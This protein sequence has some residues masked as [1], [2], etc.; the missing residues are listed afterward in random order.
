MYKDIKFDFLPE[1]NSLC[2]GR[3]IDLYIER[4]KEW[5]SDK[6]TQILL[7]YISPHKPVKTCTVS[8]WLVQTLTS[9]GID[10]SIFTG[11]ST[12]YASTSSAK[13]QGISI[14]NIISRANWTSGFYV[15][16][17]IL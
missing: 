17:K 12:R 15:P 14:K 5:R 8:R 1:D 13:A 7:S 9:A 11:H 10:T 2:V 6:N 4:T 3:T 16:Q